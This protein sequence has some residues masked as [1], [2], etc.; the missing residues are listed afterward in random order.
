MIHLK[1][2]IKNNLELIKGCEIV[3][4]YVHLLY[5]KGHKINPDCG[6]SYIFSPDCIQNKKAT[7]NPI[8][9]KDSICF[10]Y[11]ITVAL[12]HEK[13]IINKDNWDGTHFP[14]EKDD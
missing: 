1:V 7:I 3:F 9:E 11:S 4:D 12:N 14:A 10:Q 13:T 5:F 8:H 6:G 2:D